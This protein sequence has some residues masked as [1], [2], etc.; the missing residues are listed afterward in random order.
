MLAYDNRNSKAA[1]ME[2][3]LDVDNI[4][5]GDDSGFSA[6][7]VDAKPKKASKD[8]SML[9]NLTESSGKTLN[10]SYASQ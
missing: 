1:V 5:M 8:A 6:D 3:K 7:D 10:R 9:S 2:E 4:D